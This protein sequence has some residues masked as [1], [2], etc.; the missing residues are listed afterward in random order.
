MAGGS[1]SRA[2][3]TDIT[4]RP[5][6]VD[7]PCPTAPHAPSTRPERERPVRPSRHPPPQRFPQ[8]FPGGRCER[9]DVTGSGALTGQERIPQVG[10]ADEGGG[11]FEGYDLHLDQRGLA[12]Q[13]P[14][15][16]GPA[17][18]EPVALVQLRRRRIDGGHGVPEVS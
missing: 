15:W 10:E 17:E 13:P 12:P 18:R 7:G 11:D 5:S 2:A 9:G 16:G 6:A 4:G 3:N 8:P 14:Q 1:L